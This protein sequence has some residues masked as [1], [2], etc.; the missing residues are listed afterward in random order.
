MRLPEAHLGSW[1]DPLDSHLVADVQRPSS[2][3]VWSFRGR[4]SQS[5]IPLYGSLQEAVP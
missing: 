5:K 2:V 4:E 3:A 1:L